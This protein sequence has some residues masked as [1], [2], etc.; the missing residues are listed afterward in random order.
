M[1]RVSMHTTRTF[2]SLCCK[3]VASVRDIHPPWR[4]GEFVR[5]RFSHPRFP[6]D[7]LVRSPMGHQSETLAR[8]MGSLTEH[9]RSCATAVVTCGDGSV[10]RGIYTSNTSGYAHSQPWV[11]RT[12][13]HNGSPG[14]GTRGP[15]SPQDEDP[16]LLRI[17]PI[18]TVLLPPRW[19][20]RGL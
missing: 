20:Q 16:K 5:S 9:A 14:R 8:Y 1:H 17:F 2:M 18:A 11:G 10:R 3:R 4:L 13:D 12:H 19:R 7:S 15:P 6:F